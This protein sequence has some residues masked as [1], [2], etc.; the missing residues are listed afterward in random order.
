VTQSFQPPHRNLVF[1]ERVQRTIAAAVGAV[2]WVAAGRESHLY[3]KDQPIEAIDRET[4]GA[5]DV[6]RTK[7]RL[8]I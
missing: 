2:A 1:N 5:L 3:L 7:G 6:M 4:V 8:G